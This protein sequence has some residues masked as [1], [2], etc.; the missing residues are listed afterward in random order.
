MKNNEKRKRN[1]SVFMRIRPGGRGMSRDAPKK[2][3]SCF[4]PFMSTDVRKPHSAPSPIF[5]S[6]ILSLLLHDMRENR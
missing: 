4:L 5:L 2:P 1:G 3:A 6:L